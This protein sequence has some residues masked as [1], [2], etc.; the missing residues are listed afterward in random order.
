VT[1]TLSNG[2]LTITGDVNASNTLIGTADTVELRKIP[3]TGLL[4]AMPGSSPSAQAF[5][6]GDIDSIVI[7]TR[8]ASDTVFL[9]FSL[10]NFV[11]S[12]GLTFNGAQGNDILRINAPALGFTDVHFNGGTNDFGQPGSDL[13]DVTVGSDT[14]LFLSNFKLA[15]W[16]E[17][18]R[19]PPNTSFFDPIP[20][21][22]E[23]AFGF[24]EQVRLTGGTGA[25]RFDAGPFSLGPITMIG[26]AGN[27]DLV[28]GHQGDSL[29]GGDGRDTIFGQWGADFVDGGN[30][31]DEL[32]DGASTNNTI[33]GGSGNDIISSGSDADFI[34][35][36]NGDDAI[37]GGPG[38]DL[39]LGGNG[40]DVIFGGDG[41]DE[42]HGDAGRD[43]IR[44]DAGRDE[45][46]GGDENDTI[47]GGAG[48]DFL[49][50]GSGYDRLFGEDGNDWAVFD[51]IDF[52]DLGQDE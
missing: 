21:D 31:D 30:G 33:I 13:L 36:G 7:N 18:Y 50:G 14:D 23:V 5:L 6:L 37:Y 3:S 46:Y 17:V 51:Y 27:D 42:I 11:P 20:G 16:E 45:L 32:Y 38:P 44:G 19:S 4:V 39:I 10:G 40:N 1:A 2:V 29:L 24:I 35:G 28:G 43:S 9:D 25:N 48:N 12:G 15:D 34:D 49:S 22:T 52:I 41:D 26:G 47:H 8:R